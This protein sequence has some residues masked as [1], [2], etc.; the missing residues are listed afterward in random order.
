MKVSIV[1]GGFDPLHVGHIELLNK[2][3]KLT[4]SLV[5]ILN[6]D[7]FLTQK[8]GKPFMKFEER[9]VILEN[10][11]CVD[12]VIGSVDTDNTVCKT[13][14]GLA[15]LRTQL[16]NG[17]QCEKLYFCNGG[18]RTDGTNTPEHVT[19]ERLGIEPV[20]GLGGKIQSS[21]WLVS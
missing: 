10:L 21:S 14:E 4:E 20:Y 3:K 5:V 1:S 2:A 7:D 8:K 18:D 13:L 17:E 16:P 19:C 12:L 9:K 11:S 15:S 6:T